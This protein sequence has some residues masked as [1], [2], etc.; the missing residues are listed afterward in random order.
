[1][2]R[3]AKIIGIVAAIVV[4]AFFLAR[5]PDSDPA[6]M[7]AKYGAP[8]SRMIALP[9]GQRIHV[10]DEGP[11]GAPV[12]MLLHGSNADL[13]TW[14][15]WAEDLRRDFRVLMFS[16]TGTVEGPVVALGWDEG[17]TEADGPGCSASD[18]AGVPLAAIVLV[19]PANC[20]RRT[21]VLN[22]QAAGAG[23]GWL[24]WRVILPGVW[25]TVAVAF[26]FLFGGAL[27]L[28]STLSYLGVGISPPAPTWGNLLRSAQEYFFRAPH[29]LV[30]PGLMLFAAALG[31]NLLGS[32]S[33]SERSLRR[34]A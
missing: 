23:A 31:A 27:L 30:A 25:P 11:R 24:L 6:E 26:T 17:A 20:F 18:F 33:R 7:M 13:H 34:S 4:L 8:P 1:M 28:E 12:I 32:A 5:T 16:A 29:L 19:R 15:R 14:E 2:K 10:R 22:A 9:D 3:A 21:V